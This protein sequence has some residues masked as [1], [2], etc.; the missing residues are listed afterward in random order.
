MVSLTSL[1]GAQARAIREAKSMTQ[2]D[3]AAATRVAQSQISRLESGRGPITLATVESWCA[4]MGVPVSEL[5]RGPMEQHERY[6]LLR[7]L[8]DAG[9][10][11][12]QI[13]EGLDD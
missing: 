5:L 7:R 8:A 11:D 9:Q 13:E 6:A 4:G 2:S 1:V 3:A 10:I 12:R